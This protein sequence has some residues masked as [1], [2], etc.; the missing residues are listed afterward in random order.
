LIDFNVTL[1]IQFVNFIVLIFIL[2]FLLFRPLR[3]TLHQRRED[4]EKAHAKA[5]ALDTEI[6]AKTEAYEARLASAKAKGTEEKATLRNVALKEEKKLL[7]DAQYNAAE[8]R[9]TVKRQIAGEM[10]KARK[11]LKAEVDVLGQEIAS[12][13]LGRAI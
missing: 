12:K 10:T 4:V 5:V 9:E 11:M 6:D 1:L 2:N 13:V 3:R 8:K 7:E